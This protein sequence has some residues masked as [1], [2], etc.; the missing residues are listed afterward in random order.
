MKSR[1]SLS[2]CIGLIALAASF[3]LPALSHPNP[4]ENNILKLDLSTR[5]S[6]DDGFLW[7]EPLST[8]HIDI[9]YTD[10][11]DDSATSEH[12]GLDLRCKLFM[13]TDYP[14]TEQDTQ[15]G[16]ETANTI[17]GANAPIAYH[18]K[19]LQPGTVYYFKV[20]EYIYSGGNY[21]DHQQAEIYI[22][23]IDPLFIDGRV[24]R[25][26]TE[27]DWEYIDDDYDINHG[28]IDSNNSCSNPQ[29]DSYAILASGD[30][31]V[32]QKYSFSNTTPH[33]TLSGI[34]CVKDLRVYIYGKRTTGGNPHA[35][36]EV[37]LWWPGL[38]WGLTPDFVWE[39]FTANMW[40]GHLL[41]K[42]ADHQ[43]NEE[44]GW[45]KSELD[46]L[47]IW[48]TPDDGNADEDIEIGAIQVLVD[49]ERPVALWPSGNVTTTWDVYDYD[50]I[51]Q[52]VVEYTGG[53]TD[54]VFVYEEDENVAQTWAM[55]D[56]DNFVQNVFRIRLYVKGC[57][58]TWPPP[59][60]PDDLIAKLKWTDESTQQSRETSLNYLDLPVS[61]DGDYYD[62]VGWVAVDFF[63][64]TNDYWTYGE[65][66]S[67]ELYLSTP[68]DL[69]GTTVRID[70]AYVELRY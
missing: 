37:E 66:D 44:E 33:S 13:S 10:N 70:E 16:S 11:I 26:W 45:T 64:P 2:N 53:N 12:N 47:Q 62:E 69:D 14:V 32:R 39:P 34:G 28:V 63:H 43:S 41:Y 5:F 31:G 23:T 42:S 7:D 40:E 8:M 57:Y 24:N 15:I 52:G 55:E 18:V 36:C 3:S 25:K 38:P 49:E 35:K 30:D 59:A 22:K 6:S 54:L 67:L 27:Y 21:T 9:E 60:D 51:N 4:G 1:V 68:S 20:F 50:D 56:P 46:G 61:T 19:C 58:H 29:V 17:A 48:L 65:M